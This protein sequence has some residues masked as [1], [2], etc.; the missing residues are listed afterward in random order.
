M[1]VHHEETLQPV[2]PEAFDYFQNDTLFNSE[3][4]RIGSANN[5]PFGGA[6]FRSSRGFPGRFFVE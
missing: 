1:P 4:G 2:S 5:E 3:R 6:D